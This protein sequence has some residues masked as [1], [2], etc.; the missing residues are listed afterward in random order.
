MSWDVFVQE[1]PAG[2]QTLA[3]IPNDFTPKAIGRRSRIIE[4]IKQVVPFADFSNPAW[5]LIEGADFSV[6]VNLGSSEMVSSFAFH[7]RGSDTAAGVISDILTHL[8]VKALDGGTGEFFDHV[9]AATGLRRWREYK[10]GVIGR[11]NR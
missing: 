5:G 3:D 8:N 1:V 11:S 9:R 6:E 7:A 10:A 2:A 4:R